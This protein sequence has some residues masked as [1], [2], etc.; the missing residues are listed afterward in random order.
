MI[1]Q[2]KTYEN[3]EKTNKNE[4]KLMQTHEH[5]KNEWKQDH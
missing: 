1:I 3:N 2:T 4:C 5:H